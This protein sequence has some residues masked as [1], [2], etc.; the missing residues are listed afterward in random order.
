MYGVI[1]IGS[2]TVRF[3]IYNYEK[4]RI[5][6]ILS[7]K[8][9]V[10]LMNFVGSD[11]KLNEEG[12]RE[13]LDVMNECVLFRKLIRLDD[14]FVFATAALRGVDNSDE[15]IARVRDETGF[16]ID[17]LSGAKEA[18][19]AFDGA[20]SEHGGSDGVVIDIGGGST[21]IVCFRNG[22]RI[23]VDSVPAGTLTIYNRLISGVLPQP[24]EIINIS[25]YVERKIGMIHAPVDMT[26][27]DAYWVGGTGRAVRKI[28]QEIRNTSG[29]CASHSLGED[30][31]DAFCVSDFLDFY[32][33]NPNECAKVLVKYVPDRLHT[34][35]P[36]VLLFSRV[37][38]HFGLKNVLTST[39]GVREGYLIDKVNNKDN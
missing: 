7:K 3:L 26:G 16:A 5:D 39:G 33:R 23:S 34:I 36:G 22:K 15:I 8:Y 1:D 4:G 35:I 17:L 12:I 37:A 24:A 10:G 31:Y 19:Y 18:E 11:R 27:C 28:I 20:I 32:T 30:V 29:A 13:L 25:Q 2:N 38:R 14:I 6:K 9:V 21:E